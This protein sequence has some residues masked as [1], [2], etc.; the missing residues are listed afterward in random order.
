MNDLT[1]NLIHLC[2]CSVYYLKEI[3]IVI[4]NLLVTNLTLTLYHISCYLHVMFFFTNSNLKIYAS[5]FFMKF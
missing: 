2:L 3:K 1:N 5:E 4:L